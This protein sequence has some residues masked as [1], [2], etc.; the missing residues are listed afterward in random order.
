MKFVRF[1]NLLRRFGDSKKFVPIFI[2]VEQRLKK[3]RNLILFLVSF[4]QEK[5]KEQFQFCFFIE[6][7]SHEKGIVRE[8][9]SIA[10][11]C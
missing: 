3:N 9:S 7:R 5:Q 11:C 2:F 6:G 1:F 10:L 8:K 4:D